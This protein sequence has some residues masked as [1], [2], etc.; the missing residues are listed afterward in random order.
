MSLGYLLHAV[1]LVLLGLTW[2]G[3]IDLSAKFLGAFAILVGV[4]LLLELGGW[5]SYR[6]GDRR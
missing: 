2:I 1:W 5:W 4:V 6:I 3:W